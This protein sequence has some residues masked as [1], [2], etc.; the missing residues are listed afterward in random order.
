M[1]RGVFEKVGGGKSMV[2]GG[3]G[4]RCVVGVSK[5]GE[6]SFRGCFENGV[7]GVG[8]GVYIGFCCLYYFGCCVVSGF[9]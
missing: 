3:F 1:G 7:A 8:E 2:R 5:V 4:V 9:G 6:G